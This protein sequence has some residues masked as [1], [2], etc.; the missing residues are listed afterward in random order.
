LSKEGSQSIA[1]DPRRGNMDAN[2][3]DRQKEE[4]ERILLFSS[5]ILRIF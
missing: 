2:A 4:A 1:V 3:I 5:G